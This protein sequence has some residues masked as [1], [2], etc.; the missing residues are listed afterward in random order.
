MRTFWVHKLEVVLR[1]SKHKEVNIH[2]RCSY[3]G[4]RE[5]RPIRCK[6]PLLLWQ[7]ILPLNI[8]RKRMFDKR[9]SLAYANGLFCANKKK[10]KRQVKL[11]VF[12]ANPFSLIPLATFSVAPS[13]VSHA[14]VS[15]L[16]LLE[17]IEYFTFIRTNICCFC[18]DK[19]MIFIFISF[20][21]AQL[22][23]PPPLLAFV[24]LA[25]PQCSHGLCWHA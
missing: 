23:T 3:S 13:S 19:R 7:H 21:N 16:Y 17:H 5:N 11:P 1:Y 4:E 20:W 14:Y 12:Y 10:N 8:N 25:Q 6:S 22:S 2:E 18:F 9:R 15:F 24:P